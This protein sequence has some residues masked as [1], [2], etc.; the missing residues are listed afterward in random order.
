MS[1][2]QLLPLLLLGCA[3]ALILDAG[4]WGPADSVHALDSVIAA[5]EKVAHNPHLSPEKLAKAKLVAMDIKQDIEAVEHGN[6]TKQEAHNRVGSALK[7]LTAFE[8]DMAKMPA[9]RIAELKKKLAEKEA[10]LKKDKNM[11]KLLK[12]KKELIEKKLML[13]KLIASKAAAEGGRKSDEEE[14]A[15]SSA[16]VKAV[17]NMTQGLGTA[18]QAQKDATFKKVLATVQAREHEV[19]DALARADAQEKKSEAALDA[20]LKQQLP[21]LG[22]G[23]AVTK[24]QT[25]LKQLKS[26]E[27]R[28]FA[29]AKALKQIELKELKEVDAQA[30]KKDTAG[31]Q[32]ALTKLQQ[33]GRSMQAQSGKFL[34]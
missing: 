28:K 10:E 13:Q 15:K 18:A 1:L 11:M 12:L 9:D 30:A 31:L 20:A 3:R 22:K 32:K 8:A 2:V 34:Y 27:R 17:L 23:D 7:E 4:V 16:M 5:V 24:G 26:Q 25:M 29:K 14:V 6:L 19:S 21:S 33:E